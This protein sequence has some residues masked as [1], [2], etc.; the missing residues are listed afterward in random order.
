MK[1]TDKAPSVPGW[2]WL[3]CADK[4][5]E[6]GYPEVV[7]AEVWDNGTVYA[8]TGD[9]E[10]DITHPDFWIINPEWFGPITPPE[11]KP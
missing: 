4:S 1:W 10:I 7:F 8:H 3:R 5:C 6:V 11:D 9:N 2:Y